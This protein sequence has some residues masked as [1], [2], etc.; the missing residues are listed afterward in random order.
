MMTAPIGPTHPTYHRPRGSAPR[1]SRMRRAA[2]S[3]ADLGF[4][5]GTE[6]WQNIAIVL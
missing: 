6:D 4:D 2:N 1:A 3:I 5:T